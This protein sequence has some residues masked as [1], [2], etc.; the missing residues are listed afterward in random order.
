M[1]EVIVRTWDDRVLKET[2]ERVE[3]K[4]VVEFE[5]RG[6]RW[7]LDLTSDNASR[8]DADLAPWIAVAHPADA[9]AAARLGFSPGGKEARAY[10]RDL[11]KWAESAGRGDECHCHITPSG[12]KNWRY[13]YEIERDYQQHL[14]QQAQAA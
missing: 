10:R 5:Y 4:H 2:G 3:S 14:L 9:P 13:S 8:L 7:R 11:R 12:K 6:K 1:Q